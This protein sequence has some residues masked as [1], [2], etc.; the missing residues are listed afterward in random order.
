[1]TDSYRTGAKCHYHLFECSGYSTLLQQL[2][3]SISLNPFHF[4]TCVALSSS[5]FTFPLRSETT[6]ISYLCNLLLN[7]SYSFMNLSMKDKMCGDL[8]FVLI[9]LLACHSSSPFYQR[10][11]ISRM[12]ATVWFPKYRE[13]VELLNFR[14]MEKSAYVFGASIS[15]NWLLTALRL[16]D[17]SLEHD[18]KQVLQASFTVPFRSKCFVNFI[19]SCFMK[20]KLSLIY[21]LG[22]LS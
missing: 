1:M 7:V 20:S 21:F 17:V 10:F 18:L 4:S 11:F 9:S 16:V 8:T 19:V 14:V 12:K 2:V 3:S 5:N 6:S 13:L 22:E 15:D